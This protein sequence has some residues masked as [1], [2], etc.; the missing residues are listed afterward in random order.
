[1]RA[2]RSSSLPHSKRRSCTSCVAKCS[3]E[4]SVFSTGQR[5]SASSR[6]VAFPFIAG[7]FAVRADL[8]HGSVDVDFITVR[9]VEF[10]ARITPWA[11]AALVKDFNSFGPE[12][13]ANLEELRNG[14]HFQGHM[15][16]AHLA[17]FGQFIFLF[18]L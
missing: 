3:K 15:I 6:V 9:I 4:L 10:D 5:F 8:V 1:M 18:G 7:G 2:S 12:E 11:A 16:K 14:R 13:I 17:A